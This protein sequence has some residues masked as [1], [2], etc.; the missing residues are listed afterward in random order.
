M[1]M[2]LDHF[3]DIESFPVYSNAVIY[4]YIENNMS[5]ITA[6][7]YQKAIRQRGQSNLTVIF[8]DRDPLH[9]QRAGVRTDDIVKEAMVTEAQRDL[10]NGAYR[11]AKEFATR[12]GKEESILATLAQQ[13]KNFRM[14]PRTNT[15]A[16]GAPRTFRRTGKRNGVPDDLALVDMMAVYYGRLHRNS[17]DYQFMHSANGWLQ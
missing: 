6:D 9:K 17:H 8:V 5:Y 2:L 13:F 14:V 3:A 15:Q 16:I 4:V 7:I 11:I 12:P 10:S 1:D